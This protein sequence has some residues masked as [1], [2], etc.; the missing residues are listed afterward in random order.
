[1]QSSSAA[2]STG[3]YRPEDLSARLEL[4]LAAAREAGDLTLSYFSRSDLAVER[5]ADDS[6]VTIADRRAEELLRARVGE[7]FPADAILG[8]EFPE[9]PGTS[10]FRWILDPIDGTKS[11]IHGVPLYGMLV[12]VEFGGRGVVGVIAIPALDEWVYA[13]IGQGAWHVRGG[14][15]PVRA[16]VSQ[17][18]RLADG[19]FCT[20]DD[21]HWRGFERQ[22]ALERLQA[23]ARLSRTWG[24]CYGYLLVATGRAELMV[25]PAMSV[26]DAAALQ[27]VLEEAGGTFTN[28]R[29]EPTIH[30][31]EGIATNGKIL[32]EVLALVGG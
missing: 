28:W 13:A 5:K 2:S 27:P 1:M 19:L 25:D 14:G 26:W 30:S 18:P 24:D 21:T 17:T 7:A 11:F 20:S 10:G 16:A 15:E 22:T 6:P 12:A 8:E 23:A 32:A 4:A 29:G 31:G 3:D 9:R